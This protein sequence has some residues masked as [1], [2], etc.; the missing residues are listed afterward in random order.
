MLFKPGKSSF[1][2][3]EITKLSQLEDL[4]FPKCEDNAKYI[5]CDQKFILDVLMGD[6]L[7]NITPIWIAREFSEVTTSQVL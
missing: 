2:H 1:Y 6:G 7:Q 3:A 5:D 4:S